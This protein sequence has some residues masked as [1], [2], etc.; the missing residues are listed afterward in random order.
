[1]DGLV[2]VSCHDLC[3]GAILGGGGLVVCLGPKGGE[4][5]RDG[6][7]SRGGRV[8]RSGWVLEWWEFYGIEF[9][10]VSMYHSA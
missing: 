9:Y 3:Y 5:S 1:M 6:G 2:G 4:A 10:V 8:S 7:V